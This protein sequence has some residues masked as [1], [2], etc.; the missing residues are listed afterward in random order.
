[1]EA[2]HVNIY[3]GMVLWGLTGQALKSDCLGLLLT[4][5]V[6]CHTAL[7]F[8]FLWNEDRNRISRGAW[9]VQWIKHLPS[10]QV[11]ISGSWDEAPH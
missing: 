5:H 1:M 7:S 2:S 11:M 8:S 4:S 3:G 6:N 9:V 10:A